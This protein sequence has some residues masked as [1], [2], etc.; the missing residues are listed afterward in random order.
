MKS[1]VE[2][3]KEC[4]VASPSLKANFKEFAPI[5]EKV[6]SSL[7]SE[8]REPVTADQLR[9]AFREINPMTRFEPQFKLGERTFE[10]VR[11]LFS[12]ELPPLTDEEKDEAREKVTEILER[13][14]TESE[15]NFYALATLGEALRSEG[16]DTRTYGGRGVKQLLHDL[17]PED[18]ATARYDYDHSPHH[19]ISLPSLHP[20][21]IPQTSARDRIKHTVVEHTDLDIVDLRRRFEFILSSTVPAPDGWYEL[22]KITPALKAKGFDFHEMGFY[23]LKDL[24]QALYGAA[25]EIEDRG[26]IGH[27]NKKFLRLPDDNVVHTLPSEIAWNEPAHTTERPEPAPR[28]RFN[29]NGEERPRTALDKLLDFAFFPARSGQNGLDLALG[30]LARAARPERWYYGRRDPG[31]YPLLKNFLTITFER[32]QYEDSVGEDDP[33]YQPKIMVEGGYA[34]FNTGLCDHYNEPIYALFK[35]NERVTDSRPWTF[36]AFVDSRNMA[37]H[38][39]TGKFGA[40]LP[41]SAHYYDS[42]AQ[43]TFDVRCDIAVTNLDHFIDHCQ[44]LPIDFLRYFG[45][46]NFDYDRYRNRDFYED[47][48]EAIKNDPDAL[49]RMRS[50]FESAVD[51]AKSLLRWNYK[52]AVPIYYP[53]EK[54]ISLLLPL[55]LGNSNYPNV[56]LVLTQTPSGDYVATTVYTLGMAYAGARLLCVPEKDWLRNFE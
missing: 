27:P 12:V 15:D 50:Q 6:N 43:L 37:Q 13:R 26:E 35:Q 55:T 39:M 30:H 5:L 42:T 48:A 56:A 7:E 34:T 1:I 23:K 8:C 19:Y 17:Y 3:L 54:T 24:L 44:R 11:T 45:P 14:L 22:V 53:K 32:L 49:S 29:A 25:L 46:Q 28:Y 18:A 9:N 41:E 10:A 40:R 33:R 38:D 21:G 20:Y 36:V 51:D 47:L 52:R 16:F 2:I 31:T 4:Y